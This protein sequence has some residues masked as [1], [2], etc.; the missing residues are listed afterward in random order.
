MFGFRFKQ[1]Q[2]NEVWLKANAVIELP[3]GNTTTTIIIFI[4]IIIISR[5]LCFPCSFRLGS[6]L[7]LPVLLVLIEL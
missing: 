6:F 4:I 3:H 2:E 7:L 1:L 5:I